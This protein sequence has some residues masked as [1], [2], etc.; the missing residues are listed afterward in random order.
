[1]RLFLKYELDY[2]RFHIFV[3]SRDLLAKNLFEIVLD[4]FIRPPGADSPL[5][6]VNW[7]RREF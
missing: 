5:T 1:M 6:N 7:C 2:Q 3:T 4:S